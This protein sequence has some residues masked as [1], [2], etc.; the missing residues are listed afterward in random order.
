MRSTHAEI[1]TEQ[2]SRDFLIQRLKTPK[3]FTL[4][5]VLAYL[6]G[7][8]PA[9]S[10]EGQSAL[11]PLPLVCSSA[12]L[13]P[14]DSEATAAEYF[15]SHQR[16]YAVCFGSATNTRCKRGA[17]I[18]Q[19]TCLRPAPTCLLPPFASRSYSPYPYGHCGDG[20]TS[21]N[22]SCS[23]DSKVIQLAL[24]EDLFY[25]QTREIQREKGGR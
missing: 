3:P 5:N 25:T 15:I 1:T 8:W 11:R 4:M 21:T 14:Q 22:M 24:F 20:G 19:Q 9:V 10:G 18:K 12:A 17:A 23:I 2:S 16:A 6:C 7:Q 13:T